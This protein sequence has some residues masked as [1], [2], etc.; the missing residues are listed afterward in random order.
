MDRGNIDVV[1]FDVCRVGGL[2]EARRV[3][4]AAHDRNRPWASHC[5]STG[6]V[7]MASVHLAAASQT[8]F[9]VEYTM[10]ES[11]LAHELI[12]PRLQPKNGVI[13]VPEGPGLGIELN[14]D[15]IEKLKVN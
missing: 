3:A 6:I 2:T 7:I 1:Q 13:R 15:L 4:Q 12:Y 5:Y 11:K 10:S 9:Y 8:Y 14:E